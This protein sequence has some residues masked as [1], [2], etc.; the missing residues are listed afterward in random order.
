[1]CIGVNAAV[2]PIT[3]GDRSITTETMYVGGDTT[4][5]G[6]YSNG[7]LIN[8]DIYMVAGKSY[9]LKVNFGFRQTDSWTLTA[10][11]TRNSHN[12]NFF[13]I[14]GGQKYVFAGNTWDYMLVM[15]TTTD[16][17]IL[18]VEDN[19][20]INNGTS[21]TN[22]FLIGTAFR[23]EFLDISYDIV[24]VAST[25]DSIS[26]S[27][28]KGNELTQQGNNLQQQ[29]NELEQKGNEL[30][31][32][33]NQLQEEANKTSK[34]IFD[35]ISDF[36]AGFFDGIINA[37]KS[38]FI[39][40]DSYFSDYFNRLNTFF[41]KKLGMLYA[42]IDMFIKVLNSVTSASTVTSGIP[43]PGIKWEGTY[44]IAPQ[45]ISLTTIVKDYPDLQEKVYFVTNVIMI[46]YVLLLLQNKLKEVLQR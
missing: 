32:K 18:G 30:Q 27:I 38:L 12:V 19:Y 21:G 29:G 15:D 39:P 10:A 42:P 36:F 5:T 34:N 41:S 4:I 33:N 45:T 13:V 1:M 23:Y 44:I 25:Q 7:V 16:N 17:F 3:V 11:H 35:K 8:K 14:I 2:F 31:E 43:F 40:D 46:G 9:Q 24:E 37:F 20:V 26:S 22:S 28:N 6:T